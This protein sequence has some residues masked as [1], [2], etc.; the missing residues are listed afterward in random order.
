MEKLK[1]DLLDDCFR[2]EGDVPEQVDVN[3]KVNVD[4]GKGWFTEETVELEKEFME[5]LGET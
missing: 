3:S 5:L 1:I 4:K 2:C